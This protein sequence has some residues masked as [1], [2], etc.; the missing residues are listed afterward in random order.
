MKYHS[1]LFGTFDDSE[2]SPLDIVF[3]NAILE[4][5][6]NEKVKINDNFKIL[7]RDKESARD[8][9]PM[10]HGCSIKVLDNSGKG[11][12]IFIDIIDGEPDTPYYPADAK[13][14]ASDW[15]DKLAYGARFLIDNFDDLMVIWD[16]PNDVQLQQVTV[17]KVRRNSAKKNYYKGKSLSVDG[18]RIYDGFGPKPTKN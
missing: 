12:P 15:S 5:S 3:E 17:A 11:I 13:F 9:K 8:G 2:P 1:L 10:N 4:E 6:L 18:K 7:I 14:N 16:N